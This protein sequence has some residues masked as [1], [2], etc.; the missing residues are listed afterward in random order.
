MTNLFDPRFD[1][2]EATALA[3]RPK[4]YQ[5]PAPPILTEEQVQSWNLPEEQKAQVLQLVRFLATA[6]DNFLDVALNWERKLAE[7]KGRVSTLEFEADGVKAERQRMR[8]L[9]LEFFT[10]VST[11]AKML[12]ISIAGRSPSQQLDAVLNGASD[13]WTELVQLRTGPRSARCANC[14]MPHLTQDCD[15]PQVARR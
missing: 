3:A 13:L 2:R 5:M 10:F 1:Q 11:L 7:A 9:E 8:E 6:N 4:P 15:Q 14:G 12:G